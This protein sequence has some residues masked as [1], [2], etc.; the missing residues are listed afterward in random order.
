V[1]VLATIV[2][3]DAL[4]QTIWT[5]AAS[6]VGVSIVFAITV[7]GATRSAD[8]RREGRGAVASLYGLVAFTGLAGTAAAIVYAIVLITSK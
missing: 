7:L 5:A 6:G 2:D 8:L 1:T 3:L 4:W